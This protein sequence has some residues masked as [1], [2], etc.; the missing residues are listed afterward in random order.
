MKAIRID[1]HGGPEVLTIVDLPEPVA[2]PGEVLVQVSHV[3][4]N[5]LDIWVR[6]GVDSHAFPLPLI[7]GSDVVGVREDTGAMVAIHPGFGCDECARCQADQHALCRKYRIRGETTNGG[8][9]ARVAV[10][11]SHLLPVVGSPQTAAA[12]PL[13]LLT[14]WHM[15]VGRAAVQSGQLVLVQAGASGVGSLAIQ[16]AK[17][18]GARVVATAS[19][20]EK[21]A[22]CIDLGAEQAWPY[23]AVAA[24]TKPWTQG[25][26]FDIVVDHVGTDTWTSS[27]RALAWGGTFVTCGATTGHLA[28]LDLRHLFFK[29]IS[30]LGST[31]G[32]MGELRQAWAAAQAGHIQPVVDRVL[33]MGCIAQAHTLLEER[34]V[35]GKI[36]LTQDL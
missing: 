13:S 12:L 5:H 9:C 29:Q 7:P 28:T 6:R 25:R 27:T 36:V 35:L 20:E 10:P 15:L 2:G 32:G 34:K 11:I 4:L 23:A 21:R 3:G 22:L 19:T 16:V 14:A 8:M 18:H 33:S 1:R 24:E 30:V 31:M 17:M 26:G